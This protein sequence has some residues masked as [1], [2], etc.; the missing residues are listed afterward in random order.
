MAN[1]TITKDNGIT[2][3]SASAKSEVNE[4]ITKALTDAYGGDNVAMVL[5]KNVLFSGT[6][7][8]NLRWGNANATDEEIVEL[9]KSDSTAESA[10][11]TKAAFF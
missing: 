4:V 5:Q 10:L 2:K 8:D 3:M 9:L 11:V 6:I 1:Y 7:K